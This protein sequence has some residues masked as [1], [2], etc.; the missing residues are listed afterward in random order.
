METEDL[1]IS[2]HRID[3]SV[4]IVWIVCFP[5]QA[6]GGVRMEWQGILALALTIPFML[7]PAGLVLY[8]AIGCG[9]TILRKGTKKLSC[10]VNTDCPEGYNCV[11]GQCI[12]SF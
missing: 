7:F 11:D 2:R 1:L 10:S 4:C 12:P 6:E 5:E 8:L 3:F 9:Y